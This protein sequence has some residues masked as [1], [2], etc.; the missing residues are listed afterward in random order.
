MHT[1]GRANRKDMPRGEQHHNSKLTNSQALEIRSSPLTA[2]HWARKYGLDQST[3]CDIKNGK[4][5]NI[6]PLQE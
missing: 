5:Y 2:A 6:A 3:V 1:K 4:T